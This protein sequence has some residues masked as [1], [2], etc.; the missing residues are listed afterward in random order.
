MRTFCLTVL[1]LLAC[2]ALGNGMDTQTKSDKRMDWWREARFGMFIHWGLYSILAGNWQDKHGA[3]WIMEMAHIPASEYEKLVH[4][5][6]PVKFSAHDW[7]AMAKNAGMK[8]I[9][10]TTKHHDG[11]AL[12][13]S[14]VSEYD[15]MSTPFQ[16]D[17][18]KELQGECDKQG[19]KLCFYHSIMDWHHPFY[20]PRR[21]WNDTAKGATQY[22][23]YVKYMKAQLKELLTNYGQIGVLWF[24]G[25]WESTW[26]HPRGAD[27][28]DYIRKL[29][30]NILVNN[31]V[32]TGRDGMAGMSKGDNLRGDFGT[33]EQ[34]IPATGLPG[35]DWESCM[36]MNDNWGYRKD[37]LNFKSTTTLIQ[38]LVEIA[39]KGGNF[40]LNIGPTSEGL[41]PSESIIRLQEIGQWMKV[42]GE[43]IHGT[44]ATP[45]A[46]LRY[47][48][49]S[50]PGRLYVHLFDWPN[51]AIELS[52]LQNKITKAY[53]LA[54]AKKTP[55]QVGARASI[56]LPE[57]A[58]DRIDS[59]LVVEIDGPANVQSKRK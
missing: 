44:T 40:L 13:D 25:E 17:I 26:T 36:T 29:Q 35:K 20:E 11:F 48:V 59:V 6:N 16:R 22:D 15:I 41:F 5:F 21:A 23:D 19:I 53:L 28:Y 32:D 12:F 46:S 38:H 47:H 52:G 31:R 8:Y 7:V 2:S 9:V 54:D 30:P 39:S 55:L 33:P 34:E 27:L 10:I 37:D 18:L 57:S 56:Q 14:K 45:F 43:S 51:G 24:D 50:K 42:N 1:A 58:P 49:T 4:Q 3:E